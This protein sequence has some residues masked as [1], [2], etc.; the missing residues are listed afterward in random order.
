M[1]R[2]TKN[3]FIT[4]LLF[5]F[6]I[7]G[8][9]TAPKIDDAQEYKVKGAI[10]FLFSKFVQYPSNVISSNRPTVIGILGVNPFDNY[11]QELVTK[12]T[13]KNRS[14]IIKHFKTVSEVE[15]CHILFISS[16]EEA[17]IGSILQKLSRMPILTISDIENFCQKGGIVRLLIVDRN[18]GFEVNLEAA[19]KAGLSIGSQML[20]LAVNIYKSK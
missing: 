9:A 18:I 13:A 4:I 7:N 20:N 16:S 5:V 2:N 11:L 1:F 12:H 10:L 8:N 3:I 17:K 6:L 14:F 15:N 19:K